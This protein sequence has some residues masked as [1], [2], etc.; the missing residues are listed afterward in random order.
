MALTEPDSRY[1]HG[2][3][4]DDDH[5]TDAWNLSLRGTRGSIGLL[6]AAGSHTAPYD[7]ELS[8]LAG[9]PQNCLRCS[10]QGSW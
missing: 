8:I 7:V 1:I 4:A 3:R 9:P 10:C 2:V 5:W 6:N